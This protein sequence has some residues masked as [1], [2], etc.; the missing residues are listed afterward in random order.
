MCPPPPPP[1]TVVELEGGR[2]RFRRQ[3][4]P[5]SHPAK[6]AAQLY[7]TSLEERLNTRTGT[8]PAAGETADL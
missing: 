5:A 1:T 2:W 8:R 6:L 3:V 7:T 4:W